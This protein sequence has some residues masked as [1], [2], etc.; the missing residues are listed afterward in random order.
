MRVL[1]RVDAFKALPFTS[2][3]QVRDEATQVTVAAGEWVF[4]QGEIG[5]AFYIILSGEAAAI[6]SDAGG[7]GE[8][9]ATIG[10]NEFFGERALLH[11]EPRQAGVKATTKL[12][13]MRLS[14]EVY[15]KL[16]APLQR[17]VEEDEKARDETAKVRL[18]GVHCHRAPPHARP[19]W[20]CQ[21]QLKRRLPAARDG[22]DSTVRRDAA[23]APFNIGRILHAA[24]GSEDCAQAQRSDTPGGGRG[25]FATR[26][27]R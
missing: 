12:N 11:T 7:E 26:C 21:G 2:L 17:Q 5:D 13:L 16:I 18:P 1:R 6:K 24:A 8:Q 22:G 10:E 15:D 14:R 9:V 3:Q 4:E 20:S 19:D 25:A 27:A 23:R